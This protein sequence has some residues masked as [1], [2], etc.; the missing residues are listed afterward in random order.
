M[1]FFLILHANEVKLKFVFASEYLD[2]DEDDITVPQF[3]E[4]I[5]SDMNI[6]SPFISDDVVEGIH[7]T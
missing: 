7:K 3:P 5:S 6:N 4:I 1:V 2:I